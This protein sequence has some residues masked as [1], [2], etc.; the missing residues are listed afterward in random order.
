M[1]QVSKIL[2]LF[3]VV[4]FFNQSAC[5]D[6]KEVNECPAIILVDGQEEIVVDEVVQAFIV[7]LVEKKIKNEV[8]VNPDDISLQALIRCCDRL[9]EKKDL[10]CVNDLLEAYPLLVEG[11]NELLGESTKAPRQGN[12]HNGVAGPATCDLSGIRALLNALS[13]QLT[14]C[15]AQIQA[16]FAQT[17][18]ILFDI[19]Q[20]LSTINTAAILIEEATNTL[21][22]VVNALVQSA[23]S[24]VAT[25]SL[26]ESTV[27]TLTALVSEI[28]I[29]QQGT[30]TALNACCTNISNDFQATWTIL[31]S[32][33]TTITTA[34]SNNSTTTII[35]NGF[36]GTFTA[37]NAC[38]TNIT[39]EFQ[40][41][42]TILAGFN[43]TFTAINALAS[44]CVVTPLTAGTN[45]T[46]P[47][48]YCLSNDI[49]GSFTITA[50]N[51]VLD[52]NS[53]A[54]STGGIFVLTGTNRTIKNGNINNSNNGIVLTSNTNTEINNISFTNCP[55]VSAIT[56]TSSIGT[57]ILNVYVQNCLRGVSNTNDISL[58]INNL[59]I[60]NSLHVG[61][62][63]TSCNQGILSD[64]IINN[65]SSYGISLT[66]PVATKVSASTINQC[67]GVGVDVVGTALECV[68]DHVACTNMSLLNSGFRFANL[69]N[70][71]LD[72]CVVNN[73]TG[74]AS[75]GINH[76]AGF[77]NTFKS[78]VIKNI[79]ATSGV[80]GIFSDGTTPGSN[81]FSDCVVMNL[82]GAGST[83]NTVGFQANAANN[84]FYNCVVNGLTK[85]GA[86]TSLVG[87]LIAGGDTILTNCSA[88]N[89][90]GTT[91][92]DGFNI[93]S[94]NSVCRGCFVNN[95][96]GPSQAIAF[97]S[98]ID[99]TCA[100]YFDCHVNNVNSSGGISAGFEIVA[101]NN[102][103]TNCSVIC[104]TG[105]AGSAGFSSL[106][107]ELS[108]DRCNS[109]NNDIGFNFSGGASTTAD[110]NYCKANRN[111]D[112]GF[113]CSVGTEVVN[114]AYCIAE[115]NG[116]V[117]F[118]LNSAAAILYN[119]AV[120]NAGGNYNGGIGNVQIVGATVA[121]GSNLSN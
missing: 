58:L 6:Y 49:V 11:Y 62:T 97:L 20:S 27:S 112:Q 3:F 100:E 43:G 94:A 105:A 121:V 109:F 101:T 92:V 48:Y 9:E 32:L 52:L 21:T 117:G 73:A 116:G 47:G 118:D 41:T 90:S 54:V 17:F 31:A 115:Y 88:V 44:A 46:Q 50:N 16:D 22:V 60:E 13:T 93:S 108:L 106:S 104:T 98:F 29:S 110:L 19:N 33:S 113:L 55:A 120:R 75:I 82:S 7:G 56:A 40:Q 37:L 68:F 96:T 45:I 72:S 79:T 95:I 24:I 65:G 12:P 87:F 36:N 99:S 18:S 69:Q 28:V 14:T 85:A 76:L 1:K 119:Y 71:L 23:T 53:H 8:T 42:W 38:C 57:A 83:L 25:V 5:T 51:V 39:N 30:F 10:L 66:S 77:Y 63:L 15:C 114:A 26:L 70:S 4:G 74:F 2:L 103:C 35:T 67:V 59:T 91:I 81:I 84:E 34:I 86:S 111:T 107:S 89:L 102:S 61:I 80:T 64:V 78:C